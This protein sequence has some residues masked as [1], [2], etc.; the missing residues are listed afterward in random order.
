MRS[1]K[2]PLKKILGRSTLSFDEL[3]VCTVLVEIKGAI[4]SRLLMYMYDDEESTSYPL[5]PSDL[6]HGRRITSTPNAAHYEVIST[7]QSLTKKSCHHRQVL[8]QLTSQWCR[9]YLIE[10]K[11]RSQVGSKDDIFPLETLSC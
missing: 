11:E 5:T 10:L 2:K 9:E 1:F 3:H 6:I 4:N 7:N 8:Q